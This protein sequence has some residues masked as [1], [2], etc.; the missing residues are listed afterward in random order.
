MLRTILLLIITMIVVPFVSLNYGEPL[1]NEQW[2]I[3]KNAA[4]IAL[5]VALLCFIISELTKNY[6]QTDNEA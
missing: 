6:S 1:S 2:I 3:L 4:I 5:V